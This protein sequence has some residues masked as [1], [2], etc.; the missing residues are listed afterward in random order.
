MFIIKLNGFVPERRNVMKTKHLFILNPVAGKSSC[1]NSMTKAILDAVK[2]LNKETDEY[3]IMN[4]GAKGDAGAFTANT[5]KSYDGEVRV[6]AC[7]GDG[8]LNEVV[9]A[10]VDHPNVS[11][12]PVP[13]GSGND[14]VRCFENIPKEKFLD[15]NA[16][17][18]GKTV[19]CDVL[20]VDD[21]YSVNIISVG[22]DAVTG[23]RQKKFKKLP[24]ISAGAAYKVA[25]GLSF[26]TNMKNKISFEIDETPFDAGNEYVTLGVVGNGRWYGGGFKATPYAE[27][28]DG[29]IDFVTIRTISRIEF[30]KYVSIYKRGEH[31]EKMPFVKYVRCK[32]IKMIADK[33]LTLQLDGEI[34]TAKD[35]VVEVLPAA[36][37]IILPE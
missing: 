10:A 35:P 25:L 8:T 6:Y 16:C 14:F 5:A 9:S 32:K 28:G 20:K 12:C 3:E 29:L 17:L 34:Y 37:R 33:P 2:S 36:T 31:I 7:G 24:L 13:V 19:P 18:R 22:L 21:R 15:I 30:L 4:T 27:I 26:L 1:I 11:V 23:L